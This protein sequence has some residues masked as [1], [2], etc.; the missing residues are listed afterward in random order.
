MIPSHKIFD[1]N[2]R[3][4]FVRQRAVV[5]MF[6]RITGRCDFELIIYG[7][8]ARDLM[9]VPNEIIATLATRYPN[10]VS[11]PFELYDLPRTYA[12]PDRPP[13]QPEPSLAQKIK[14]FRSKT[15]G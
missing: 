15:K 5:P 1:Y 13:P 2:D 4:A 3:K 14:T 6:N 7:V 12:D 8:S 10:H 11:T 9:T